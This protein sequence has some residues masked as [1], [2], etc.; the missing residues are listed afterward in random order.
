VHERY[1]AKAGGPA[2]TVTCTPKLNGDGSIAVFAAGLAPEPDSLLSI[3]CL[4]SD[5]PVVVLDRKNRAW[6]ILPELLADQPQPG[7]RL[8]AERRRS[9]IRGFL[10]PEIER[11]TV[12]RI[13]AGAVFRA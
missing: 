4:P 8:R 5:T 12:L 2:G 6:V 11:T 10:D 9:A 13:A 7:N 1:P 3:R